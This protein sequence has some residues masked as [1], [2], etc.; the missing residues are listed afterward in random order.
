MARHALDGARWRVLV[1]H[2]PNRETVV[3]NDTPDA[4]G[5]VG[6]RCVGSLIRKRESFQEAVEFVLPAVEC[7]SCILSTQF[8]NW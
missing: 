8:V 6:L 1:L 5:H 7:V 2:R 4:A 3:T